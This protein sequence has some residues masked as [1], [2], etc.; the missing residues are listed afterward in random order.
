M[1]RLMLQ[2]LGGLRAY[3]EGGGDVAAAGRKAIALLAYLALNPGQR[4]TRDRLATLLWSDRG[5][6]H[7]RDGNPAPGRPTRPMLAYAAG[8]SPGQDLFPSGRTASSAPMP[9]AELADRVRVG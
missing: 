1:A 4:C 6:D 2:L 9:V 8:Q 7:A 5:E 3:R